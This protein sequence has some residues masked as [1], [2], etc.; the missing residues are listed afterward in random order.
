MLDF[1]AFLLSR[2]EQNG[3]DSDRTDWNQLSLESAMRGLDADD[4]PEY[5][6]DDLKEV[7]S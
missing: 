1:V 7:Y 5:G 2:A 4:E 6:E 3:I